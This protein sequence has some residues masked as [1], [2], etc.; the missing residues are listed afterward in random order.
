[1]DQPHHPLTTS[2]SRRQFLTLA[3][4]AA[5]AAFLA[6]C[7]GDSPSD[8]TATGTTSA[9][10]EATPTPTAT[11]AG[12]WEYTDARGK[13]VTLDQAPERV[14]AWV[15]LAAAMHDFGVESVGIFGPSR[16]DDGGPTPQ[17]GRLDLDALESLT[18]GYREVD[19]E[20]LAVLKPDIFL[21]AAYGGVIWPI[22]EE[23]IQAIERIVPV[24]AIGI[25]LRP[26]NEVMADIAAFAESLAAPRVA[27]ADQAVAEARATFEAASDALRAA[28]AEK[29]DL[30]MIVLSPS[31][32]TIWVARWDSLADLRYFNDLGVNFYPRLAEMEAEGFTPQLTWETVN[33]Y[34]TDAIL[35]DARPQ[36]QVAEEDIAGTW[37]LLPA[38]QADQLGNWR[39]EV[40][41][42]YQGITPALQEMAEQVKRFSQEVVQEPAAA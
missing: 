28:T 37:H 10:A 42:S 26:A 30:S 11:A 41:L 15:T 35:L 25:N 17:A 18:N 8:A 24:V 1:L 29:P 13:T 40:I 21:V 5:V 39:A 4:S 3:G 33:T 20:R 16:T 9:P 7:G 6:A 22:P 27:D 2:R 34:L 36:W 14:V 32:E 12:P 23:E 31:P 19:L 38:V